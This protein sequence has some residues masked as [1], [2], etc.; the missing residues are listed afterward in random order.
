MM[1][2]LAACNTF[3]FAYISQIFRALSYFQGHLGR[4]YTSCTQILLY[5][6]WMLSQAQYVCGIHYC[7]V[8][9]AHVYANMYY[10][11]QFHGLRDALLFVLFL[12]RH[13]YASPTTYSIGTY[14]TK[15]LV[16]PVSL[17]SSGSSS[18]STL[19]YLILLFL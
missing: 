5:K 2:A 19:V 10:I 9:L 7:V 13:R 17:A 11:G 6:S 15:K 16:S 3:L 1:S 4:I 18:F 12:G 8:Y 14:S